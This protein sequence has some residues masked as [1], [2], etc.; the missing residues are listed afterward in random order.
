MRNE[1]LLGLGNPVIESG[2]PAC[3]LASFTISNRFLFPKN[4]KSQ[5]LGQFDSKFRIYS[6][7]KVF[8]E[9]KLNGHYL[10]YSFLLFPFHQ[11]PISSYI[12]QDI[13][14]QFAPFYSQL[15]WLQNVGS[16]FSPSKFLPPSKLKKQFLKEKNFDFGRI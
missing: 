5:I 3:Y 14:M 7:F 2:T 1:S 16:R 4:L 11:I 12:L 10:R 6:Y 15:N 8:I 13:G 9:K